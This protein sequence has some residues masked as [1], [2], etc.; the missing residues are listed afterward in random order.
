METTEKFVWVK[1]FEGRYQIGDNG[2]LLSFIKSRGRYGTGNGIRLIGKKMKPLKW[3][4]NPYLRCKLYNDDGEFKQ[5]SIHKLVYLNFI[6]DVP[7]FDEDG[8][9]L[10]ISHIDGDPTNC[11]VNNLILESH[12]ENVNR[13]PSNLSKPI[14]CYDDSGNEIKRYSKIMDVEKDG[15]KTNSIRTAMRQGRKF[16]NMTWRF[17]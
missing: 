9:F 12:K 6:S 2:T 15:Y 8:N 3:E 14:A 1:G 11:N 10:D 7:E 13:I 17:I 16:D 4:N 5:F